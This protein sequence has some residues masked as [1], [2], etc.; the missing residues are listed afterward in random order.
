[1]IGPAHLPPLARP[2]GR[3]PPAEAPQKPRIAGP[4]LGEN[5]IE[6]MPGSM[7][8]GDFL[9]ALNPLHHIPGVS[10]IYR[11]L[12]GETIQP[13]FRVL[14]GLVTGGPIGAIAAAVGAL[15][16]ELFN[17]V[18]LSSSPAGAVAA[19]GAEAPLATRSL[20]E[21]TTTAGTP[22]QPLPVATRLAARAYPAPALPLR[23]AAP[24]PDPASGTVAAGAALPAPARAAPTEAPSRQPGEA[25][26]VSPPAGRI[27][28]A[29]VIPVTS[30]GQD[31]A[32]V[33]RMMQGL[34]AYERVMRARTAPPP[35]AP[36][37]AA[38]PP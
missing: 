4:P 30:G 31:P 28:R 15:A 17:G 22:L 38:P 37:P 5:E 32:F 16:E 7:T 12:T 3:D 23:E 8:F 20:A 10:W 27:R 6:P 13:V 25:S 34:E 14:G 35:A 26:P 24:P 33:Q 11:K 19:A 29:P 1:M 18:D 9:S 36:A 2:P 21:R